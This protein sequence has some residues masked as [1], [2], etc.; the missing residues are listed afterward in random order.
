M[1]PRI[2]AFAF[3]AFLIVGAGDDAGAQPLAINP[4]AAASDIG[5]PSSI[6][7]A[8]AAS[9][10]RNPS[11]IN[12]SAAASQIPQPSAL[13]SRPRNVMPTI[14]MPTIVEERIA[15]PPRRARAVQ[16]TRRGRAATRWV[17]RR[18]ERPM[19]P[20]RRG[21]MP[22]DPAAGIMGSVCRGC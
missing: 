15:R 8:A 13:P 5:N 2:A 22:V 21:K 16:R 1:R 9:D 19:Q 12:P 3:A 11:A 6:N 7:P 17:E 10:I 20:A 14:L 18:Q 4:S